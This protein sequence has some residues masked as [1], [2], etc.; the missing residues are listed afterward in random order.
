M[1]ELVVLGKPGEEILQKV[2]EPIPEGREG[3]EGWIE[4]MERIMHREGGIGI[5]GPQVG[6]GSRLFITNA[7]EDRLRVF[8]N[9][10]IIETSFETCSG[11]EGCLSIP[12]V[13]AKVD[14]SQ[15]VVVKALD[16]KGNS[17]TIEASGLLARVIQH[18][19]DHL[20]GVLFTDH[21]PEKESSRLLDAYH[22]KIR[23]L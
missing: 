22:K 18:E 11:E 14:R 6:I 20:N 10:Q 19:N 1:F 23:K 7:P 13:Q 5:A 17:F 15:S 21:L 16:S 12:G 4:S 2:A 9:P 3:L 8:V